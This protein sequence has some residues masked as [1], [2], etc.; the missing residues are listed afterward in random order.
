MTLAHFTTACVG[1]LRRSFDLKPNIATEASAL[2]NLAC[3]RHS[4][5]RLK[6]VTWKQKNTYFFVDQGS[7]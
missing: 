5:A 4:P 7:I 1:V 2:V 6:N 3:L